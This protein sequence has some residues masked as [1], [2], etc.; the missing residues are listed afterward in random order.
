MKR[1]YYLFT[2]CFIFAFTL[3]GCGKQEKQNELSKKETDVTT[4]TII[5]QYGYEVEIPTKIERVAI[6]KLLPL[7][8]VYAV[9][10]GGNVDG[11]ISMPP[12][13]LNAAENSILSKY[14]PDILNVS[15]DYYKGGEL[16]MEELLKLNPDVVFFSGGEEERMQFINAGIPAVGFSTTAAPSTIETMAKWIELMEDVFQEKSAVNGIL[17]YAKETEEEIAK[18]VS[19]LKEED[20][21]KVLIIGHYNDT[22]FTLGLFGEYWTDATGS[23][24]VGKGANGNINME[25]VY[26]WAPDKIFISTLSDFFPEDFYQNNTVKGA[27]WSGVPAVQDKEVYKFPLGIHRWWPPSTDGPLALWW[28]AKNTYP[29]LFKDID[30]N[31]KIKEFYNEFYH[32]EL[33]DDD[34][35][36]IL[37][38]KKDM[39]RNYY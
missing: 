35:N 9:Y 27:D 8:S 11:L 23:I 1:I 6:H 19:T 14:A 25:Q 33:T 2:F 28:V 21:K 32:M 13:S 22:N 38:P 17:D 4:R 5:D 12:D 10:K 34:V 7:P 24:N 36:W 29:E 3:T 26:Q 15:I 37:N 30:I 39:G 16:N 18:R 31:Q 20:K